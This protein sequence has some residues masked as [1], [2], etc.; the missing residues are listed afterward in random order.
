MNF[1]IERTHLFSA[2][3][4]IQ[5]AVEKKNTIPIL[6]NLLIACEKSSLYLTATDL[7]LSMVEV[8]SAEI[9]SDGATTT[10][11]HLLY[12]IVRKLPEGAQIEL[13]TDKENSKIT[14]KSGRSKF[15]LPCL[16][17][18]EFP[19]VSND[20]LPHNFTIS[21]KILKKLLDKTRFAISTEE[22][23]YYLNGVYFHKPDNISPSVLRSVATDG[24]RLAYTESS[25][26]QG[27]ADFPNIIVPRKAVGELRR[28][29]DNTDDDINVSLSDSQIRFNV[30]TT[31]ITT[32]LIDGTFPDYQRVIPEQNNKLMKVN[33]IDFVA[34]VDR[35]STI[36]TEK[37]RAIKLS[38]ESNMMKISASSA[39]AASAYEEL[40]IEYDSELIEIGFNSKY[41]LDITHHVQGEVINFSLSDSVSP[42]II[43]DDSDSE[44]LFVL[45]PMRV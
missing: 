6:S 18:E 33:R 30:G 40:S 28:L 29:L 44:S 15:S 36:S 17:K 7:D 4:H 24:H 38:I 9:I 39:D 14:I 19:V 35:V 10:P 21:S 45:M 43:T 23:R 3:S 34:A 5:N 22:T 20:T 13:S 1:K 11:A 12:E 2:L 27:A 26:P 8:V 32:K 31:T 16:S 25:L 37:S 41:L 42:A